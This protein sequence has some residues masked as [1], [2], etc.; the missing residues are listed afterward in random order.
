MLKPLLDSA[1][2]FSQ[3]FAAVR[4]NGKRGYIDGTGAMRIYPRFDR[5][6]GLSGGLAAWMCR[7]DRVRRRERRVR[8]WSHKVA[9]R[10]SQP[11]PLA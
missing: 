4:M 8:L 3:G 1:A 11:N 10:D 9:G 2:E 5:A 6:G 7:K